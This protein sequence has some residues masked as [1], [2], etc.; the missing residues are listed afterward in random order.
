MKKLAI[1]LKWAIIFTIVSLIWMVFEKTMGWHDELISE[2]AIYTNFFAI[3]A[4][5]VYVFALIDKRNNFYAGSMSYKEGFISG[6]IVS[7]M[8]AV[9]SPLAQ[10]ITHFFITPE[11]F[12][13][14]IDLAVETGQY[15]QGEAEAYFNFQSYLIQAFIYCF[16]MGAITSAIV[17]AFVRKK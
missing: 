13:N 5:A 6:L 17:A 14:A 2:H 12:N 15:T 7:A 16:V 4:I 10:Y 1:E 8:V 11:Y 3:V 9:L